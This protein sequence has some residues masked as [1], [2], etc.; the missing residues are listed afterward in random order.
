MKDLKMV[1]SNLVGGLGNYLFQIAAAYSLGLDNGVNTIFDNKSSITVHK[2]LDSYKTNILRNLIYGT[3][4]IKNHYNEQ[5]FHYQKI[6]YK[7]NIKINGYYQSEKYFKHNRGSILDLFSI[8]TPS[9]RYMEEKYGDILKNKTCSIHVRRGDY[10]GLPNH[11]PV[12]SLGYYKE[13]MSQM[14]VDKFLVFSDDIQWCKENFTGDKFIFIEGNPDYIDLWLMSLCDNNIIANS[15]F[16][17][18]GAWLN[19]NP[20]KKVIAPN[21]WF[22]SATKHN[23][24]DLIPDTWI[25]I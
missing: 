15:S 20:T 21:K 22:G 19:Q 2:H 8:N 14:V 17:W 16:S 7:E 1:T 12:C 10:L 5:F 6:P 4:F 3:P 11:H 25:K 13:A 24:K 9:E 23:T 18:W